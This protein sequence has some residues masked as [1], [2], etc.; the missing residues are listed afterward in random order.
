MLCITGVFTCR[1]S[2][3]SRI[4]LLKFKQMLSCI[5]LK[6]THK[7]AILL[8]VIIDDNLFIL[9]VSV[10]V[11]LCLCLSVCLSV[12][13]YVC[14][15]VCLSVC[16]YVCLYVSLSLSLGLGLSVSQQVNKTYTIIDKEFMGRTIKLVNSSIEAS[17]GFSLVI[18]LPK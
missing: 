18:K 2:W 8:F 1:K 4:S 6:C 3:L 14:V 15:Y 7:T 13:M 9:S 12:C 10:F 11:S 17:K 5:Y 16:L